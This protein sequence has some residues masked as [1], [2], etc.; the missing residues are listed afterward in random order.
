LTGWGY[1]KRR[2][3]QDS[4]TTGKEWEKKWTL[5]DYKSPNWNLM[6][7]GERQVPNRGSTQRGKKKICISGIGDRGG[8]KKGGTAKFVTGVRRKKKA[9]QV[10]PGKSRSEMKEGGARGPKN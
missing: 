3:P 9:R 6:G 8:G 10:P 4:H 1:Q 7:R 2:G 5:G